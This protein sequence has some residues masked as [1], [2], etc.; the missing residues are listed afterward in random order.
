[1][2]FKN[3][4]FQTIKS[5]EMKKLLFIL[6]FQLA[7]IA[8]FAQTDTSKIEQYCQLIATP[9]L[10]SNKVTIDIDFGEEKS[11]WS[12]DRL[13]T[14]DGKLKKFNTIIDALNFMGK[15]GWVFINAY[16]VRNGSS[17]IYHYGFKKLFY[18]SEAQGGNLQVVRF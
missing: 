12:D 7:A 9:R 14:Y 5:K 6:F 17:D 1:V 18:Q 4:K 10:F 2:P 16:P 8:V 11:F 15:Q 3:Q 13:R